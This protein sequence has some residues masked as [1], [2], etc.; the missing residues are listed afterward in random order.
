MRAKILNFSRPRALPRPLFLFAP[1]FLRFFNAKAKGASASLPARPHMERRRKRTTTHRPPIWRSPRRTASLF[2]TLHTT[3]MRAKYDRGRRGTPRRPARRAASTYGTRS[4]DRFLPRESR[5]LEQASVHLKLFAYL[6]ILTLSTLRDHTLS[7]TPFFTPKR[8]IFYQFWRQ[9]KK[10]ATK[11]TLPKFQQDFPTKNGVPHL[12]HHPH[13][14]VLNVHAALW[15]LVQPPSVQVIDGS[16]L[17][18][19]RLGRG[20]RRRNSPRASA[21]CHTA[22]RRR[23]RNGRAWNGT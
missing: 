2:F 7:N 1:R 22:P 23:A 15:C 13:P 16:P 10:D 6:R 5:K 8:G 17:R 21:T 11:H 19:V 18:L 14:A 20:I 3:Q 4:S 12:P 9:R